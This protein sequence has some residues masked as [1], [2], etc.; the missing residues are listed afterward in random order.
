MELQLA[1]PSRIFNS[2]TNNF[3]MKLGRHE[4]AMSP[5]L[6]EGLQ[7]GIAFVRAQYALLR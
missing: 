6:D 1:L 3:G 5:L 4:E 2:Y 7:R